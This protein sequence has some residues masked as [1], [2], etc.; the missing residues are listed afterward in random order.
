MTEPKLKCP[1][2]RRHNPGPRGWTSGPSRTAEAYQDQVRLYAQTPRDLLESAPL[3]FDWSR[4]RAWQIRRDRE[5]APSILAVD[6]ASVP[7]NHD[8]GDAGHRGAVHVL[9]EF[10]LER[11]QPVE[12]Q[13][14]G[15]VHMAWDAANEWWNRVG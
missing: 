6:P 1:C 13:H 11:N 5:G 12:L 10:R 3:S 14:L 7:N 4:P 15:D 8:W 2:G 9:D